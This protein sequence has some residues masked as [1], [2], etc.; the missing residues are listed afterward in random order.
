MARNKYAVSTSTFTFKNSIF[1]YQ[2]SKYETDF[3]RIENKHF[4]YY[5]PKN[6]DFF[7]GTGNGPIPCINKE[8]I[9]YFEQNYQVKPQMRSSYLKDGFYAKDTLKE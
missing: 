8:Q 6:I 4:Y 3:E 2:N 1:P 9:D 7:W 5:S